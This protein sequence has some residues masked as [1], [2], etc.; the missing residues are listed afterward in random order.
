MRIYL[1]LLGM[2]A[3]AAWGIAWVLPLKRKLLK[4]HGQHKTNDDLKELARHG[5]TTAQLLHKRTKSFIVA[6][7]AGGVLITLS[8]YF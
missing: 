7:V 4:T 6:G 5:D 1:I 8:K 3:W 2:C